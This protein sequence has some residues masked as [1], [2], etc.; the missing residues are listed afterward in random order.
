[1]SCLI[2]NSLRRGG[3][4]GAVFLPCSL[5]NILQLGNCGASL[6]MVSERCYNPMKFISKRFPWIFAICLDFPNQRPMEVR[7]IAL[8]RQSTNVLLKI[9]QSPAWHLNW[10]DVA[11]DEC[12]QARLDG[13]TIKEHTELCRLV[14]FI[15]ELTFFGE[16]SQQIREELKRKAGQQP[17]IWLRMCCYQVQHHQDKRMGG[18]V[19][20]VK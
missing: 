11:G 6:F 15:D 9:F 13:P 16:L 20:V 12:Q 4:Q 5:R 3:F 17:E 7:P 10:S 1:M 19:L 2:R 18:F 14:T 8:S